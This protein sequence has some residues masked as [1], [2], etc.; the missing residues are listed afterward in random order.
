MIRSKQSLMA[1]TE[2]AWVPQDAFELPG[3]SRAWISIQYVKISSQHPSLQGFECR[4][5]STPEKFWGGR[6]KEKQNPL[7]PIVAGLILAPLFITL[8]PARQ[9][10]FHRPLASLVPCQHNHRPGDRFARIM[11]A[12]PELSGK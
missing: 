10:K 2:G 1:N 11:P 5:Y 7:S 6:P 8:D 4:N 3:S 9:V 12:M